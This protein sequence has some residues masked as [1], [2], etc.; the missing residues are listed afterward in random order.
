MLSRVIYFSVSQYILFI[1][2]CKRKIKYNTSVLFWRTVSTVTQTQI[3]RYSIL[4][5]LLHILFTNNYIKIQLFIPFTFPL[6]KVLHS[7][8]ASLLHPTLTNHM[9]AL[10]FSANNNALTVLFTWIC[11]LSLLQLCFSQ[12]TT[13][14]F[15]VHQ[16]LV[17]SGHWFVPITWKQTN[18]GL[19]WVYV[20]LNNICYSANKDPQ[21][22]VIDS[23]AYM[24]RYTFERLV[25]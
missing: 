16:V 22:M 15:R 9:L 21:N 17:L 5:G 7:P 23:E 6:W 20:L 3:I 14:S 25:S 11:L 2:F 18:V 8:S 10:S 24:Q 19:I 12:S 1:H 13:N 4:F